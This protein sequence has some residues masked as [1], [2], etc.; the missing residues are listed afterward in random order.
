MNNKERFQ[1]SELKWREEMIPAAQQSREITW[2]A[3][4]LG[5]GGLGGDETL[6]DG[7][8]YI[9]FFAVRAFFPFHFTTDKFIMR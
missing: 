5:K 7:I 3:M 9:K 2:S 6:I 1:S 4:G 8:F